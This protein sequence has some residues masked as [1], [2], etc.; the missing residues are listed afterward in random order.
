MS[1]GVGHVSTAPSKRAPW[2]PL[3]HVLLLMRRLSMMWRLSMT[4]GRG[5][6][7]QNTKPSE[8][9]L[10]KKETEKLC[11]HNTS[12]FI[13]VIQFALETGFLGKRGV[14]RGWAA[15]RLAEFPST[16]SRLFL[17]HA[18]LA[19]A[20]HPGSLGFRQQGVSSLSSFGKSVALAGTTGFEITNSRQFEWGPVPDLPCRGLHLLHCSIPEEEGA[21]GGDGPI[22][23]GGRGHACS[24]VVTWE[25]LRGH[26]SEAWLLTVPHTSCVTLG[27]S[28]HLS[29][30]YSTHLLYKVQMIPHINF[31]AQRIWHIISI[32]KNIN[33]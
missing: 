21:G 30:P 19:R 25:D 14:A 29:E 9:H 8:V 7:N 16:H 1:T 10:I 18:G 27:K 4:R 22:Q 32:Q 2:R 23:V 28:R 5:K 26:W 15:S 17:K 3:F 6:Q 13:V 24:P 12:W 20:M 33:W 11:V 31:W